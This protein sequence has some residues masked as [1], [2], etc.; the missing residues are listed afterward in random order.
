MKENQF[1]ISSSFSRILTIAK[2]S[3]LQYS[4]SWFLVSSTSPANVPFTIER[5]VLDAVIEQKLEREE[6]GLEWIAKEPVEI[7]EEL[8][9][10]I[11]RVYYA[12]DENDDVK[13][14]YTNVA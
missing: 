3:N 10:K 14:I 5:K 12:F 1:Y 11:A 9:G 7:D 13:E 8:Q 2:V 4:K 6:S